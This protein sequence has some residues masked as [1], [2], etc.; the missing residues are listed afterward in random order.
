MKKKIKIAPSILASNFSLLGNEI[1]DICK[2]G[3]DY[4]VTGSQIE[5]LPSSTDLIKFTKAVHNA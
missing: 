5:N 4:I 2:A 3:A 1:I